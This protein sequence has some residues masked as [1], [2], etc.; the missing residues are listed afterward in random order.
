MP[1]LDLSADDMLATT[2][3]VRKRLDFS[4]PVEPEVIR[5]CLELALQAPTGGNSQSWQFV[6]VTDAEKRKTL[7]D[8]YRAGRALYRGNEQL[9]APPIVRDSP[10]APPPRPLAPSSAYPAPPNP[11]APAL[12]IS[13]L[14][15]ATT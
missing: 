13:R 8:L 14:Q 15:R 9:G 5:E 2:R 12:L 1:Q 7:G 10:H 11:P 4:R 3:S 6:V